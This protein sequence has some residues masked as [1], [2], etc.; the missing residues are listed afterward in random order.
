MTKTH[1]DESFELY[2]FIRGDFLTLN[3]MFQNNSLDP[4]IVVSIKRFAGHVFNAV[5]DII[6]PR[7]DFS[8]R[9]ETVS[10][11]TAADKT[12]IERELKLAITFRVDPTNFRRFS[13]KH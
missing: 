10:N 8:V 13:N 3:K 5:C 11:K 4:I 6:E 1:N 12:G 2:N 7:N 9:L